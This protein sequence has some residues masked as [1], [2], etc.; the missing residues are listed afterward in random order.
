MAVS[1]NER[2]VA[3]EYGDRVACVGP[4]R[5]RPAPVHIGVRVDSRARMECETRTGLQH[6]PSSER[7]VGTRSVSNAPPR[8]VESGAAEVGEGGCLLIEVLAGVP[9]RLEPSVG[10]VESTSPPGWLAVGERLRFADRNRRPPLTSES[11]L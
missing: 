6:R 2:P 1:E 8:D 9:G 4:H 5:L 3:V 11:P 10:D 7:V